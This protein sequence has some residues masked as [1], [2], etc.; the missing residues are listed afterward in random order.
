MSFFLNNPPI[1][2]DKKPTLGHYTGIVRIRDYYAYYDGDNHPKITPIQNLSE[3]PTKLTDP[4]FTRYQKCVIS[5]L[6]YF[7]I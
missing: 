3:I 4:R 6:Y 7:V 2:A 5:G 1:R